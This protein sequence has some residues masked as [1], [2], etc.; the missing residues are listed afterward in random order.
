MATTEGQ[1]NDPLLQ[2]FGTVRTAKN[3]CMIL[4]LLSLLSV[5]LSAVLMGLLGIAL[6]NAA[7]AD[8]QELKAAAL[9]GLLCG[10]QVA[11]PAACLIAIVAMSLAA[12]LALLTRSGGVAYYISAFFWALVL[13]LVLI[14]WQ[15]FMAGL[16]IVG[17]V[18]SYWQI[19][20][21]TIQ[22]KPAI[23][24]AQTWQACSLFYGRYVAYPLFAIVLWI[25]VMVKFARGWRG[26]F[27]TPAKL[28]TAVATPTGRS[29]DSPAA[30]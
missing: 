9:T 25:I 19:V 8:G 14:P 11:A 2:A 28:E 13:L 30:M 20:Q 16:T 29:P 22:F 5:L 21:Y 1:S 15:Q 7:T 26:T 12:R 24:N 6:P 18:P 10:S 27:P 17:A 3:I 23:C 4:V